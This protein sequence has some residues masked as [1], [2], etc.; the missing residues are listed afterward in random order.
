VETVATRASP[1]RREVRGVWV[2]KGKTPL[3]ATKI[4]SCGL[5]SR[6]VG[7]A[8]KPICFPGACSV[9]RSLD[10][11]NVEAS[12]STARQL[13]TAVIRSRSLSRVGATASVLGTENYVVGSIT[14]RGKSK[15]TASATPLLASWS[16]GANP[17]PIVNPTKPACALRRDKTKAASSK[18]KISVVAS[19]QPANRIPTAR[20]ASV[21]RS[22]GTAVTTS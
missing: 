21:A 17:T 10:S 20:Q 22:W 6:R 4:S 13:S 1:K 11:C 18:L 5:K 8:A 7:R 16:P 12:A 15:A 3:C 9:R 14:K 19:L 2:A